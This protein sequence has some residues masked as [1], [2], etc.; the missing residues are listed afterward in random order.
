M[1]V[2][3]KAVAVGSAVVTSLGVTAKESEAG[4]SDPHTVPIENG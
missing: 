3:V 4:F 2:N 1:T